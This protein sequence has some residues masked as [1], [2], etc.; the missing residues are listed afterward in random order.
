MAAADSGGTEAR[1]AHRALLDAVQSIR[2]E[3]EAAS[4]H[5]SEKLNDDQRN[6]PPTF[7]ATRRPSSI[8]CCPVSSG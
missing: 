3:F 8:T 4:T 7:S 1:A 6:K 2:D 5:S